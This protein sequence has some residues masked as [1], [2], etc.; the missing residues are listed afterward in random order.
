M[1]SL[2]RSSGPE[3][4]LGPRGRRPRAARG[5][6]PRRGTD[7]A[8]GTEACSRALEQ[9]AKTVIETSVVGQR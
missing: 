2:D 9:L 4:A 7:W 5:D 3:R 8:M 1:P 6:H